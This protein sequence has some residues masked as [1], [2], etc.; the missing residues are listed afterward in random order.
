MIKK[1]R[2][3]EVGGV[4]VNQF[5]RGGKSSAIFKSQMMLK[6][7]ARLLQDSHLLK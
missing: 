2:F 3:L 7:P 6:I 1:H 4:D 5:F